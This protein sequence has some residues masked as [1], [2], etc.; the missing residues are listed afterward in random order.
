MDEMAE[1]KPKKKKITLKKKKQ[2]EAFIQKQLKKEEHVHLLHALS[3]SSWSSDLL[4]SSKDLGKKTMTK[5]QVQERQRLEQTYGLRDSVD[6]LS[7]ENDSASPLKHTQHDINGTAMEGVNAAAVV[8]KSAVS[9]SKPKK[10][11]FIVL[12]FNLRVS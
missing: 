12:V 4:I 11:C 3:N 1:Q 2:R 5:K 9:S 10:V 7:K 6:V 8:I